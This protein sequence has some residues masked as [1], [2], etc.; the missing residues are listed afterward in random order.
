MRCFLTG[1][2]LSCLAL[3]PLPAAAQVRLS[4]HSYN[5][6]ML[7]GR[8]PHAFIVLEG[9]LDAD[10]RRVKENYGYAAVN[11]DAALFHGNVRGTIF[12]ESDSYVARTNTHFTVPIS[13]AQYHEIEAE[14]A[15]WRHD[16]DKSYGL[17][18]NNCTHFTARIARMIGLVAQVPQELVR[19]PK[20]WLNFL[21]RANPQLGAREVR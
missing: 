3:L 10:G 12:S 13:D 7:L 2:L 19:K 11:T 14:V 8:W 17:D 20:A 9:T 5:G 18:S 1:F 16:P 15:K 21:T 4:F 6:S